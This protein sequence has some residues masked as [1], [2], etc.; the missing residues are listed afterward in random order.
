MQFTTTKGEHK[1]KIF[2]IF[3]FQVCGRFWNQNYANSHVSCDW[4]T[5]ID[6]LKTKLIEYF[7]TREDVDVKLYSYRT[8]ALTIIFSLLFELYS[9]ALFCLC[10]FRYLIEI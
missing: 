1:D 3:T 5:S 7:L 6:W 8:R 4:K 10:L 9:V 2:F